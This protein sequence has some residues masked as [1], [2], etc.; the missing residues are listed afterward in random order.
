[1][2]RNREE[3]TSPV[4]ELQ[5]LISLHID[6]VL[7][8]GD[9]SARYVEATR[10]KAAQLEEV[11]HDREGGIRGLVI[12]WMDDVRPVAESL[13][14]VSL[15][16]QPIGNFGDEQGTYHPTVFEDIGGRVRILSTDEIWGPTLSLDI[17]GQKSTERLQS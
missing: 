9:T 17:I 13:F 1:M 8:Q 4:L 12:G 5:R 7:A 11:I 6:S 3:I 15:E 10:K 14:G 16:G 2:A